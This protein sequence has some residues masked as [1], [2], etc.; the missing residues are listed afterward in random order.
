MS[1]PLSAM[2]QAIWAV[3]RAAPDVVVLTGDYLNRSL[4][5]V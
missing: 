5:F 4:R 2:Q 3:R 1:T